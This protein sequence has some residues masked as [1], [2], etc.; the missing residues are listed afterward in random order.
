MV[1]ILPRKTWVYLCKTEAFIWSD[2]KKNLYR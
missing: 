1:E 2:E